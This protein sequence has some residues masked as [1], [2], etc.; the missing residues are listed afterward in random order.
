MVRLEAK[1]IFVETF[2]EIRASGLSA[3]YGLQ[4]LSAVCVENAHST[5]LCL[6]TPLLA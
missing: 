3:V 5:S 1:G 4:Q 6:L 2:W